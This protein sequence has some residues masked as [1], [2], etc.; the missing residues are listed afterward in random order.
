METIAE[1]IPTTKAIY[2]LGKKYK[3]SMPITG[4]VFN[5]VYKGK[6]PRKAVS[7]LMQRK[8]KPE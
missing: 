4:E 2:A 7:D 3:I 5:I 8:I 1:G 6:P